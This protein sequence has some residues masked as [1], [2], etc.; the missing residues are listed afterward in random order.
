MIAI[1]HHT[2]SR[3]FHKQNSTEITLIVPKIIEMHLIHLPNA[4]S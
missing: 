1:G 2:G 4:Y 3:M